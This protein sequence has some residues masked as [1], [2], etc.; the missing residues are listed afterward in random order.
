[1]KSRASLNG[2][3]KSVALPA[4]IGW[5]SDYGL[6]GPSALKKWDELALNWAA[7][8]PQ[9]AKP[10]A[11]APTAL[12]HPPKPYRALKSPSHAARRVVATSTPVRPAKHTNFVGLVYR[13]RGP[14][15]PGYRGSIG[16]PQPH[17]VRGMGTEI[18]A[19]SLCD[20]RTGSNFI[21]APFQN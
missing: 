19:G 12:P 4:S 13:L 20:E 18:G 14:A 5:R 7:Q 2:S 8:R 15:R 6:C 21:S 1:V 17:G 16:R 11:R 3:K 10:P 9:I